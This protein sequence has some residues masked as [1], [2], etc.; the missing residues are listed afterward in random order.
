MYQERTMNKNNRLILLSLAVLLFVPITAL[1]IGFPHDDTQQVGC[2]N[3][4]NA[5]ATL[6]ANLFNN[7][8]TNCHK[9][10]S[11]NVN[12]T[13]PFYQ[14][15][16][17]NIYNRFNG[18]SAG[19]IPAGKLKFTSHNWA[20]SEVAPE[21]GASRPTIAKLNTATL[22]SNL[23]CARCHAVHGFRS[24]FSN[25]AP[26]L[27]SKNDNDEMCRDC[28]RTRDTSNHMLGSHPI[29]FRYTSATSKAVTKS[30]DYFNPP[31]NANPDNPTSAMKLVNG[32]IQCTSCHSVHFADS[33]SSTVDSRGSWANLSSSRGML[34][35]TDP[36]GKTDSES[37]VNICTNCHNRPN[38]QA[39][40]GSKTNA[41]PIQ[42][43]DCH[44]GHVEY[45]KPEDV[46]QGGENATPNVYMLRRYVNYS[47]GV[48]LN[49]YRRKAFL[50]ST[51]STA[52]L[53][54]NNGTAVCQACHSLP[55]NVPDHLTA[56]SKDKCIVC[57]GGTA[58]SKVKPIGCTDC[59]GF[60]PQHTVA[61]TIKYGTT[62]SNGYAVYSSGKNYFSAAGAIYK[63]ESTAGH[64]THA[65][66]KPYTYSCNECHK[67]NTHLKQTYQ[68]LF[69][70]KT[71]IIAGS[72]ATFVAGGASSTCSNLYC[73]SYGTAVLK[74]AKS[75]NWAAG[76]RGSIVG[77]AGEC[78]ACHNGVNGGSYNNMSTGSHFRHVSNNTS[79]GKVITCNVCHSATV[80]SNTVVSNSANHVNGTRNLS[81]SELAAGSVS[82]GTTC[83]TYCHSNGKGTAAL[84][85][86]N[87]SD[88]NSGKCGTCHLTAVNTGFGIMSSNAHFTHIS[89]SYGPKRNAN[90]LCVAC[91][92][93]AGELAGS[94][95][96]GAISKNGGGSGPTYCQNCHSQSVPVW[97]SHTRLS[98]QSCHSGIGNGG[99]E[100]AA[101]R[102]WSNYDA[103]GVQAPYKSYS[104]F[105][106]RGHGAFTNSDNCNKCHNST[107]KHFDQVLGS[108]DKR[109]FT[110]N[111]N[112]QCNSCHSNPTTV[113][114][115][116][117]RISSTHATAKGVYT[118]DCK[119]CHD[120]HGTSNTSMLRTSIVFGALTSTITY[121]AS[122]E[123]VS[124]TPPYRGLCQTCH[125]LTSHYR[126]NVDEGANHPT[127]GCLNCHSHKDTYAFKPKA[128]NECHGYPPAPKGFLATQN[129][130]SSARLENYSGGGGAHVKAGHVLANV[131]PN[132]GFAPCVLCHN[133]GA[134]G[135]VGRTAIFNSMTSPS[136]SQKKANTSVRV[137]AGYKFN[138]SKP[139]DANQ[140]RKTLPGN[141]GSCWNVSCHFQASPRWSIDK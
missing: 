50:T 125:T 5:T 29:N 72:A 99:P 6:G 139:L 103:T 116:S 37:S 64:P 81:F 22:G 14:T 108:V 46:A 47:A 49:S 12:V 21:A 96:D 98:C 44:S 45:L 26:F 90:S 91:H 68:D 137:D 65:A 40:P 132:Q 124:L 31:R 13:S 135:H 15:D 129:N 95:V 66:G 97:T 63:N 133:D 106:N 38:H 111:D 80:S 56:T 51:S 112:T 20:G 136:T 89:S 34:L 36:L 58:H 122:S 35:R 119:V 39:Y 92:V 33:N 52:T 59:H 7:M 141:T 105:V 131:R 127:T 109:L 48:K 102:S 88:R 78:V 61:G 128:C 77:T 10:G 140:Y 54:N 9:P 1:G 8:C 70:D 18:Y 120:V 113:T 60:P 41:T 16:A 75:I 87:W 24:S 126:R 69:V 101:N 79:T 117:K 2:V 67:G 134:G 27:R 121:G 73:H 71:G 28:H 62:P 25:S 107:S 110:A 94:H 83:T 42:C 30:G 19:V 23:S 130:F 55:S 123:L 85:T 82:N 3:C 100:V 138:S 76:V 32:K 74:G 115:V 43:V 53:R 11:A 86:P 104:T 57:H 84:V 93:F 17:A 4:H 118:M 114:P